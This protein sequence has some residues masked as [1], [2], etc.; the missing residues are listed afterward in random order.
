MH[1]DFRQ[2]AIRELQERFDGKEPESDHEY[3]VVTKLGKQFPAMIY[4]ELIKTDNK[5]K[6]LR[7]I[8]LILPS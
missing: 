3:A 8:W 7:C 6:G 2:R 4:A 1:P 5:I